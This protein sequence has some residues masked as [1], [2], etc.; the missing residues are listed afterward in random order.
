[1][2]QIVTLNIFPRDEKLVDFVVEQK[3]TGN[4]NG[5]HLWAYVNKDT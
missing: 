2:L 3:K 1:M 5:R 4:F